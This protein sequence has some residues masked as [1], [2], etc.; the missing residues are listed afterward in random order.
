MK[1]T[2]KI[3]YIGE[4]IKEAFASGENCYKVAVEA[5][6]KT[7]YR[8]IKET[9]GNDRLCGFYSE[10]VKEALRKKVKHLISEDEVN[11]LNLFCSEFNWDKSEDLIIPNPFYGNLVVLSTLL[12]RLVVHPSIN[13][14]CLVNEN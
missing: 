1:L 13:D 9:K 8:I 14:Q 7:S 10:H 3:I 5:L 6:V 2:Q 4:A 11:D 12:P